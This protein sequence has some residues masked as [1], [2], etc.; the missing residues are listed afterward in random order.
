MPPAQETFSAKPIRI[1]EP[2]DNERRQW[3]QLVPNGRIETMDTRGP[4]VLR[5]PKGVIERSFG[6]ANTGQLPIDINHAID[7][8]TQTG[9]PS[10]AMGWITEMQARADGVWGRIQWSAKAVEVIRNREYRF[11]SPVIVHRPGNKEVLA[12]RRA[13]LTNDP[14]LTLTALNSAQGSTPMDQEEFMSQLRTALGL[15]G[16]ADETAVIK[17]AQAAV[18]SKNSADP[19]RF[20]PIETFQATVAELNSMRSGVSLMSAEAIVTDALRAGRLMPYMKDWAVSLCQSNKSAFDAFLEKAGPPIEKFMDE[21]TTKSALNS[22]GPERTVD[23]GNSDVFA[24]MGLSADDVKTFGG[25]HA[26]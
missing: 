4:F 26:G 21:L 16:A 24:R 8:A 18:T 17:A 23:L 10:P 1:A 22:R 20:V 6:L 7:L 5:D 11:L 9:A 3:V 12:I 25:N 13:S 15:D 2:I 14:N 19:A